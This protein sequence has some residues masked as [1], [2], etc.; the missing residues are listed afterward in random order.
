MHLY[1]EYRRYYLGTWTLRVGNNFLGP[2]T[3]E[4]RLGN[5]TGS[6]GARGSIMAKV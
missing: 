5:M 1:R 6:V 3:V 4:G 2:E